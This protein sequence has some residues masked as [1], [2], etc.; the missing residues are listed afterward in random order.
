MSPLPI[1]LLVA[2][3]ALLAIEVIV[4]SFGVLSLIAIACGVGSVMVA[5]GE[6]SAYGWSM[7]GALVV[8]TPLVLR[9]TFLILPKL[10]FARGL[11]LGDPE[12]TESD[13][14]AAD[15]ADRTLLGETGEAI[16]PLRPSGTALLRNTRHDVMAAAGTMIERGTSVRVIEI[17][18]NRIIVEPAASAESQE[19]SE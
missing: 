10:P 12:L 14:H 16:T 13:R 8:G 7:V 3:L 5:F 1:I 11:Y 9:G 6:S 17:S 4:V 18:A 2:S 15:Q 19:S